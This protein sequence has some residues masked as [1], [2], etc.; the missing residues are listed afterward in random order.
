MT[1]LALA[2]SVLVGNDFRFGSLPFYLSKPL[3][4]WHYVLGKCL[5]V[6]VFINLQTTVLALILWLEYGFLD[7]SWDY[8]L[9]TGRLVLGILGYGAVLTV[10]LSLLLVA[11]ASWLRKTVPMVMVW[12]AIFVFARGLRDMLERMRPDEPHWRLV[13]LWYDAYLVGDWC[14]GLPPEPGQP[15][16]WQAA[17]VLAAV[18]AVCLIYLNRRIRAVEVV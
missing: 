15:A 14:L 1:V 2:G 8:L 10:F 13:D 4:R 12:T 18:V 7:T 16:V 9:T 17:L 6:A 11:T 5:A 3:G